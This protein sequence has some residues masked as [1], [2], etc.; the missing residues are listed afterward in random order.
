MRIATPFI[1]LL[2]LSQLI[3]CGESKTATLERSLHEY[4]NDHWLLSEM[5]AKKTIKS[6][7][8]IGEAQYMMGLC[9]FNLQ[10]VDSSKEW[11]EKAA[12]SANQ[13]V[14]GKA[15]AMLGIIAS[16]S[17]DESAAQLAF[18]KAAKN[19]Q[20]SDKR[21]ANQ[22]TGSLNNVVN[23]YTLQFG[24]Y[25][26]K[27]NARN[28]IESIS[29]TLRKANLG[30]A[31]IAE[32]TSSIGRTLYLVQA[33]HFPTRNSASSIRDEHHLPQ[34]VVTSIATVTN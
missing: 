21:I 14:K 7:K 22:R 34:C 9:E 8:S 12:T 23:N 27:E 26:N 1:F 28:A 6:G 16:L 17:G 20:G 19:L 30:N 25:R 4:N 29:S 33:G 11:F 2:A 5:W 10:K 18:K 24:A 32:E 3:S 13:E 31:W 15:T